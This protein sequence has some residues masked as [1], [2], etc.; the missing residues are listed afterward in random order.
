MTIQS[1]AVQRFAYYGCAS[2]GDIIAGLVHSTRA[3][4]EDLQ[5]HGSLEVFCWTIV[6][7]PD[8][9]ANRPVTLEALACWHIDR[10]MQTYFEFGVGLETTT[11]PEALNVNGSA[12]PA[13]VTVKRS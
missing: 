9:Y 4:I 5:G 3:H 2:L 7:Q 10:A 12:R 1:G 8:R 6:Q 13:T 11:F